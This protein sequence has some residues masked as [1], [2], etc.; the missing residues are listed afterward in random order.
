VA[1]Q[2]GIFV[3]RHAARET[4]GPVLEQGDAGIAAVAENADGTEFGGAEHTGQ[5]NQ[6]GCGHKGQE[7]DAAAACDWVRESERDRRC[8]IAAGGIR[9]H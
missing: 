7:Q 4:A 2:K 1:Y 8:R 6:D 9:E 3:E 5:R